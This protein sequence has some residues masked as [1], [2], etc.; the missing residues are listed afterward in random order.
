M[1]WW[2]F[3]ASVCYILDT[4]AMVFGVVQTHVRELRKI[5]CKHIFE[6]T[7]FGGC[8]VCKKCGQWDLQ[9]PDYGDR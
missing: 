4:I 2:I 7:D 9:I 6:K 5:R 3:I 1:F 8:D